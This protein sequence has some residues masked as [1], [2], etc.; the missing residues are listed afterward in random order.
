MHLHTPETKKQDGYSGRD[1]EE[2]WAKFY[3]GIAD[4]VGDGTDPLR[5]VC[6]VAITD[7]LSIKN[8]QKVLD[9]NKLPRCIKF[10][11]P[12]VE[13]RITPVAKNSPINIHCLFSPDIVDELPHRFFANLKFEVN[14]TSYDAT[15]IGLIRLGRDTYSNQHLSDN[16]ALIKGIEQFV[17][18]YETLKAIFKNDPK[19]KE[20]TII[21]V[22]NKTNDGVSGLRSHDDPS[23]LEATR[24]AIYQMAQ[25]IFSSN[26]KDTE[27]FL[28]RGKDKPEK[29]KEIYG[30]LKPCIHGCD[31]HSNDK[32]FAPSED[33]F[34][35]IKADPT[36]E[37][38]RQIIYEPAERVS[39]SPL[40]PES[41]SDYCVIDR[42]EITGNNNFSPEPIYFNEGLNC[43]IGGKST[44][45]S[46][47]LH[48]MAAALD[49]KQVQERDEI[50]ATNVKP[51]PE[52]KVFWRDGVCSDNEAVQ[53]K[54]VYIP[55]SYLNRLVD[56][57]QET[58]E[59]DTIIQDIILQDKTCSAIYNSFQQ[60]IACTRQD[61]AKL[62]VDIVRTFDD[63]IQAQDAYKNSGDIEAISAEVAKLT[64]QIEKLSGD[65]ADISRYEIVREQINILEHKADILAKERKIIKEITPVVGIGDYGLS[66][67]DD[68][69]REAVDNVKKAAD[70]VW[71]IQR[72]NIDRRAVEIM[73]G[74]LN[75][76]EEFSAIIMELASSVSASKQLQELSAKL[77][78]E[79]QKLT[80]SL[81]LYE[82][83]KALKADYEKQ[84]GLLSR[85]FEEFSRIYDE[86]VQHINSNVAGKNPGGNLEFR[87]NKVFRMEKFS[88]KILSILNQKTLKKFK[89]FD[90]NNIHESDLTPVNLYLL[91]EAILAGSL[92]VKS[93][94]KKEAALREIL[95]DW[96]NISY[97][98]KTDNDSINDMSKGKKAIVLLRLLIS[99]AESRFPILIDQPEDDLDNRSIFDELIQF[100]KTRKA[101]RQI[102]IVTH[103][104]NIVLGADA[105]QVIVA[106]QNGVNTE[107][108]RCHFEYKCGAIEDNTKRPNSRA[109]LDRKSIK[110]HIC[111]ILEGGKQAFELRKHKYN[112]A[113]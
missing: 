51:V 75:G 50:S 77:Q 64:E 68:V 55:Q 69:F 54:I 109:I 22:A 73:R 8:Y 65:S 5:A 59:I 103:N 74:I 102:I 56:N 37:G 52:L 46:L 97:V 61:M 27:Y 78:E 80:Q 39:I 45:K 57:E 60:D 108:E 90:L 36:F 10:V 66:V 26:P 107:N 19:L 85:T 106:N 17:V 49:S 89:E 104:A 99:L 25:M 82:K 48:N 113:D 67:L 14:N 95:D 42:V 31:A 28:G 11:L 33:R 91:I 70:S 38:L 81:E 71:S 101:D 43:I 9:N 15:D 53:R 83:I 110:E 88:Q 6:A 4:Y 18:H 87:V 12:N 41:K 35:W 105:E 30:S 111:E 16:A 2:K 84:K 79:K 44:G 7:Y 20:K 58:T 29:V 3:S 1:K 62:V 24:R 23:Q 86:Y 112:F 47:L 13:M 72:E 76:I 92:Q 96:Y 32:I 34:C 63:I 40:M 98:V 93:G 94:N 21:V 100:I